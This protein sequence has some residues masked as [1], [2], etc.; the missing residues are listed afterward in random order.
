MHYSRQKIYV[1]TRFAVGIRNPIAEAP[2]KL[3]FRV[4]LWR[5]VDKPTVSSRIVIDRDGH[6]LSLSQYGAI[7]IIDLND[8]LAQGIALLGRQPERLPVAFRGF[9]QYLE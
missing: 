7:Q 4:I 5:R 3:E 2:Y 9:Y 8:D 6:T 1:V